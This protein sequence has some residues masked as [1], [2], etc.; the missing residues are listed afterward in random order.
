MLLISIS[1]SPHQPLQNRTI[2]LAFRRVRVCVCFLV[3]HP[4]ET[5]GT[6]AKASLPCLPLPLHQSLLFSLIFVKE[7]LSLALLAPPVA[8]NTAIPTQP[9]QKN[10]NLSLNTFPT[11]QKTAP[12]HRC[13]LTLSINRLLL[14][15]T[16]WNISPTT[17]RTN[18]S[19]NRTIP[20][21]FRNANICMCR[22]AF[23]SALSLASH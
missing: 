6:H 23:T 14:K 19:Q 11:N 22:Y 3:S 12:H 5:M 21:T 2:P 18:P 13:G 8:P 10:N 9:L 20:L 15:P 16:Q 17:P 4:C 1:Y 7:H